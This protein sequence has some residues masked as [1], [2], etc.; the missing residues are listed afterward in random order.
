MVSD[1]INNAQTL[2][3]NVLNLTNNDRQE[4]G[5]GFLDWVMDACDQINDWFAHLPGGVTGGAIGLI[6]LGLLMLTLYRFRVLEQLRP[7]AAALA[8]I[9]TTD[10]P[11]GSRW[12]SAWTFGNEPGV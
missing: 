12:L 2:Y 11:V 3:S 1:L 7:A 8:R 4:L 9:S 10:Q 6:M 5:R